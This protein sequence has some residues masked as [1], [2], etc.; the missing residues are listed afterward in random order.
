MKRVLVID[1]DELFR[2][3]VCDTLRD[4]GYDVQEAPEGKAGL[5]MLKTAQADLVVTD[6][7]MPEKE[8]LETIRQ[9]VKDHPAVHIIAISGGMKGSTMDFLPMAKILGAARVFHKPLDRKAFL[10]ATRELLGET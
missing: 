3:M 4:A 10:A 5:K 6:L 9:I 8:G 1:D 2:S 7:F